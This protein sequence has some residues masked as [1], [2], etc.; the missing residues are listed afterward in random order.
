M[1]RLDAEAKYCVGVGVVFCQDG[2]E[3][4]GVIM[5]VVC[6]G[7][8][9]PLLSDEGYSSESLKRGNCLGR[10]ACDV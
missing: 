10:L 2:M 8:Q 4:L 6:V 5:S 7:A 3:R 1:I 9:R